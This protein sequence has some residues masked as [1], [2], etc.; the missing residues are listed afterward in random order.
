MQCADCRP[1]ARYVG[2]NR[3][4]EPARLGGVA[5]ARE[6]AGGI[7]RADLTVCRCDNGVERVGVARVFLVV[8]A[9]IARIALAV[10][11]AV[12]LARIVDF[13]AVVRAA[14]SLFGVADVRA[15]AAGA[16]AD[17]AAGWVRPA[18]PAQAGGDARYRA[19]IG[20]LVARKGARVAATRRG[21]TGEEKRS[22]EH[23]SV[24][25]AVPDHE[26]RHRR[27]LALVAQSSSDRK[28]RRFPRFPRISEEGHSTSRNRSPGRLVCCRF[29]HG[30][31][32]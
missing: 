8:G 29:W 5:V 30:A 31:A 15:I 20:R 26:H 3:P 28:G 32:G 1:V 10:A 14:E 18:L 12:D 22:E 4:R 24:P 21:E 19:F 17:D 25:F 23:R 2:E 7:D 6:S 9:W 13:E 16:A 11:V 27:L